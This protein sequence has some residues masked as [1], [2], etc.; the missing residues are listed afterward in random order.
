VNTN[1]KRISARWDGCASSA[2]QIPAS[3]SG[4]ISF[5]RRQLRRSTS[6]FAVALSVL[7][8]CFGNHSAF[9]GT[10]YWDTNGSSNGTGNPANGT[11]GVD[12]FWTTDATGR[13]ATGAYVSGSDV[14][15]SASMGSANGQGT[16]AI[17][18]SGTQ[19]AN[20]ITFNRGIDTLSGTSTPVLTIAGGGVTINSTIDGT[21]TFASSLSNIVVSANQ[22]WANNSGQVFNIN[23]GIIGNLPTGNI[24]LSFTGTGSGSKTVLGVIG[25]GSGGGTL[26]VTQNSATSSLT[27]SGANTF[28]GTTTIS[29]GTLSVSS[30][31]NGGSNSNIGA[32]TNAATNLV[33]NG[34][35]LKYTGATVSTD[36]LFSVGTSGGTL[37]ASGTGAVNFTN[38]G[39][40][41]FSSQTGARTLTLTG[42]NAANNTL[43]AVVGNNSG[44]TSLT[45]SGTG[46]W[47]LTGNNTFTGTT[48]INSGTLTAGA[49]GALGSGT[50]GTTS[51]TVNSGGTLLL[52]NSS[53]TD[54]INNAATVTLNGGGTINSG[55]VSEGTRPNSPSSN[56]GVAGMGALT[57]Q[58]TSSLSHA[59]FDFGS[60]TAGSSLVFSSLSALSKGAF[61]D[62][63]NWGGAGNSDSG[64]GTNDRLLFASDPGYTA[65]DLA[66]FTFSG[67]GPGAL[68]IAYGNMFEI[69]PI[70]E[71]S[72]WAA[73]GLALA[74]LFCWQRHRFAR[75]FKRGPVN[76]KSEIR[77]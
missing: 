56:N 16:N 22:N 49:A 30:L 15:F 11:W 68:E 51:I 55:G 24:S 62:I 27:L 72:T 25:N 45:K 66:N 18:V 74:S 40:M 39:A 38:T 71:P 77:P 70:P 59:V 41:G 34:G 19:L 3:N 1:L 76:Q 53:T 61:V 46:T 57:L 10:L 5:R 31:A 17:T 43:A 73:G 63:L 13:S 12:S 65:A 29:G 32:S 14:F 9:A 58:N 37:D 4:I 36:R 60:I 8:Y 28:T 54:H 69:V 21:T 44:A 7:L 2:R 6:C 50:T 20:S 67:F 35:A 33:L 52:S 23:S 48:T 75:Y 26:S 42:A 64:A 47:V